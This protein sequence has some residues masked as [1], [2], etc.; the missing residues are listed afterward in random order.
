MSKAQTFFSSSYLY[1]CIWCQLCRWTP[2]N[3]N[4]NM[5]HSLQGT[6]WDMIWPLKHLVWA[7]HNKDSWAPFSSPWLMIILIALVSRL[8]IVV[9]IRIK[10]HYSFIRR[11]YIPFNKTRAHQTY[12]SQGQL[13]LLKH[14]VGSGQET[15]P[16]TEHLGQHRQ[17]PSPE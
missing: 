8:P 12:V 15:T 7:F 13:S 17:I 16:F 10:H 3:A 14:F 6:L 1:L 2:I 5:Q 11:T 4:Q 9:T